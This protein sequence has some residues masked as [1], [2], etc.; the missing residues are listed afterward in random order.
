MCL[1]LHV[2]FAG[3]LNFSLS[4]VQKKIA[5]DAI[6][7]VK[8]RLCLKYWSGE[9]QAPSKVEMLEDTKRE[10]EKQIAKDYKKRH[11][12]LLGPDQVVHTNVTQIDCNNM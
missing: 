2:R 8:V 9:K 5:F 10:M 6:F 11:F 1:H 7:F 4:C 3:Q 12:H